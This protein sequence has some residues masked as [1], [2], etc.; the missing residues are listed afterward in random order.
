MSKIAK[1]V[2]TKRNSHFTASIVS[3]K[4]SKNRVYILDFWAQNKGAFSQVFGKVFDRLLTRLLTR[5]KN[6]Q[7]LT[8]N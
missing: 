7:K 4:I 5:K 2:K 6:E 3:F 8:N 1:A